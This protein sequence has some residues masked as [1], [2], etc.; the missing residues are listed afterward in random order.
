[1]KQLTIPFSGF[2][3]S[4][5]G[6]QVNKSLTK[7]Q[8]EETGHALATIDA[9]LQWYVGDWLAA[10]KGEEWGY[11]DL[12]SVCETF[13]LNYQTARNAKSICDG[14]ELSR[15]RDNLTFTHHQEVQGRDDADELLGWCEANNASRKD[16]REE[17]KRRDNESKPAVGLPDG[18]FDLI[19][20]DPPWRYDDATPNRKVENHYP[21][22][23]QEQLTDMEVPAAA[24]CVL[25][26]WA[27][28]PKVVEAI[29]LIDAWG[30]EYK[31]Q[32]V[33]D[34]Q[35]IGMGYWFR[36][37]HEILMVATKG[38]ATPPDQN[39]RVS[40]VFSEKRG[41]HSEKPECVYEWIERAFGRS[42][43]CELFARLT[44]EGWKSW[45]N[46]V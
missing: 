46:E 24:D 27:T 7:E 2:K 35:K 14:F 21:T 13:G 28:A 29:E 44:R 43:K 8:W 11:G 33:W 22:M 40:S 25:L 20:A 3:A 1:M 10:S 23:C 4:P 38:N 41:K 12:E 6:L 17:K 42:S 5:V 39:Q 36:G 15:R 45:G 19:L 18:E 32:A 9:R 16:L 26:M 31:T 34:K 37:Q 30:F